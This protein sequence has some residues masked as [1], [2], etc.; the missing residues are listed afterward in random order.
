M[1]DTKPTQPGS[2]TSQPGSRSQKASEACS[3]QELVAQPPPTHP[4]SQGARVRVCTIFIYHKDKRN[5][6]NVLPDVPSLLPVQC[7]LSC[8]ILPAA[9]WHRPL[10]TA[11]WL[12]STGYWPLG[13]GVELNL[14]FMCVTFNYLR[15]LAPDVGLG[16]CVRLLPADQPTHHSLISTCLGMTNERRV[17]RQAAVKAMS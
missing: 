5:A 11:H 9:S 10:A 2:R 7:A 4:P 1:S 17:R 12:L 15:T 3:V 16:C 14:R 13:T 8:P 6:A